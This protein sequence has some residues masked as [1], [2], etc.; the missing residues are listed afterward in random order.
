MEE[1]PVN[2]AIKCIEFMD[3]PESF[4][5]FSV[6]SNCTRIEATFKSGL[7]S[8]IP[9]IRVWRD[10]VALAEFCQ[11]TLSGVYFSDQPR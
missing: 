9:Y 7:Y 1:H 4:A 11:H 5:S 10:D 2:Q 3:G 6:G 8:N